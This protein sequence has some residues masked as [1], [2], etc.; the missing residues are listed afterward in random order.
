MAE[1]VAIIR[2]TVRTLKNKYSSAVPS[3][4]SPAA[5][6]LPKDLEGYVTDLNKSLEKI[7]ELICENILPPNLS[8]WSESSTN[9]GMDASSQPSS[10]TT[11]AHTVSR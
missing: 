6:Y 11:S 1:R 9:A 4:D 7:T 2:E 5:V 3:A 10:V 8:F